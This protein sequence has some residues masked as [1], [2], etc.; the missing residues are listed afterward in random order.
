VLSI[1]P[2]I[3]AWLTYIIKPAQRCGRRIF[4]VAK[5]LS[6]SVQTISNWQLPFTKIG[7]EAQY[8]LAECVNILLERERKTPGLLDEEQ[9]RYIQVRRE[10]V[11]IQNK[12]ALG[13]L[14]PLEDGKKLI[15]LLALELKGHL[16][17]ISHRLPTRLAAEANGRAIKQM[18][19]KEHAHALSMFAKMK[20]K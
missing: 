2:A 8:N 20:F 12:V 6:V 18:L 16:E 5:A 14:F 19:K 13:E 10:R 7:K 9:A 17:S 3:D 15:T 1:N 11:E 4:E